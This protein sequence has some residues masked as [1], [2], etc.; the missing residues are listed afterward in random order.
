MIG[1]HHW[2]NGHKSGQTPGDGEG[3]GS[4]AC[5]SPWG[6]KKS[7]KTEQ[8]NN[9]VYVKSPVCVSEASKV[10]GRLNAEKTGI[11]I[12]CPPFFHRA[13]T[14]MGEEKKLISFVHKSFTVQQ[15]LRP[16]CWECRWHL[17]SHNPVFQWMILVHCLW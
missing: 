6:C 13:M 17:R 4:L 9:N 14:E 15:V 12:L 3:Q 7:D 8:L 16:G 1:W 10:R 11:L 5:C 2:H